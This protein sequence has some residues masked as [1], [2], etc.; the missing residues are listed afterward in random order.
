MIAMITADLQR[1]LRRRG[2]MISGCATPAVI[3]IAIAVVLIVLRSRSP[4]DHPDIGGAGLL[5]FGMLIGVVATIFGSL[6]GATIGAEDSVNGTL[7]Y[8]LLTGVTRLQLFLQRIPVVV[9]SAIALFLPAFVL[10]VLFTVALPHPTASTPSASA[11]AAALLA[12][13]LPTTVYALIAYGVGNVVRSTGG[14]IAIA[15]GLNLIGLQVIA[16]I[17]LALPALEPWMLPIAMARITNGGDSS[18]LV[19]IAV[20]LIWVGAFLAGGLFRALRSE[21]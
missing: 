17:S 19:A 7:R 20:T 16:A 14:A 2:L 5:E 3:T 11:V 10:L 8:L 18:I 6:I 15:L 4:V 1:M 12:I 13:A 21:A 9:I